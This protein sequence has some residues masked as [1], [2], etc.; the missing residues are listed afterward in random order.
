MTRALDRHN[1]QISGTIQWP[2]H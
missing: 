1:D 2:G